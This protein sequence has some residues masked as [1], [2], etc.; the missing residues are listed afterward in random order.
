MRTMYPGAMDS[1]FLLHGWGGVGG[2]EFFGKI[3]LASLNRVS[4]H[5]L[6]AVG[7]E[8]DEA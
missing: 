5:V 8:D 6:F 4:C 7:E 2:R 1:D 3:E